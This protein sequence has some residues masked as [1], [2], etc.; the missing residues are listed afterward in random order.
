MNKVNKNMMKAKQFK[1]RKTNLNSH[2]YQS[3]AIEANKFQQTI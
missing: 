3:N 2:K 1:Y